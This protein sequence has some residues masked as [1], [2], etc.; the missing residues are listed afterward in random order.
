MFLN[1][2]VRLQT[3]AGEARSIWVNESE[4]FGSVA[5]RILEAYSRSLHHLKLL[6]DEAREVIEHKGKDAQPFM[7]GHSEFTPVFWWE[8]TWSHKL[9]GTLLALENAPHEGGWPQVGVDKQYAGSHYMTPCTR[10]R[11][12]DGYGPSLE[13]IVLSLLSDPSYAVPFERFCQTHS[14]RRSL[15]RDLDRLARDMGRVVHRHA[16]LTVS[17]LKMMISIAQQASC[18]N[19]PCERQALKSLE[20]F[21]RGNGLKE[22]PRRCRRK[23]KVASRVPMQ[24]RVAIYNRVMKKAR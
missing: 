19:T 14:S 4:T 15:P 10:E 24:S 13:K 18:R 12:V 22:T 1:R 6:N 11:W 20:L 16:R 8:S 23:T 5:P 3:L 21:L 9:H 2:C 17:T 7:D